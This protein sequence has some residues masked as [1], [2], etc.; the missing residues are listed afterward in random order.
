MKTL[1]NVY[2]LYIEEK[3]ENNINKL[4]LKNIES[5]N[6]GLDVQNNNFLNNLRNEVSKYEKLS[7]FKI[8]LKDN[9][10]NFLKSPEATSLQQNISNVS[11]G[12]SVFTSSSTNSEKISK[13]KVKKLITLFKNFLNYIQE[14]I[15]LQIQLILFIY[16]H[17]K[18]VFNFINIQ[19][20]NIKQDDITLNNINNATIKKTTEELENKSIFNDVK[21]LI[22]NFI[23]LFNRPA[24]TGQGSINLNTLQD[25]KNT[26]ERNLTNL[27]SNDGLFVK[28]FAYLQ[29]LINSF[30]STIK[31]YNINI[32]DTGLK[33]IK[34][35][36]SQINESQILEFI[37]AKSSKL[38]NKYD[39]NNT[40]KKPVD[41]L[42]YKI[43]NITPDEIIQYNKLNK[44]FNQTGRGQKGGFPKGAILFPENQYDYINSLNTIR[45]F[46]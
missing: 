27:I 17:I 9:L 19:I 30:E 25:I 18:I 7:I 3:T 29:S 36:I 26:Y 32:D 23:A 1:D 40:K 42:F 16:Y 20:Q 44:Y 11:N 37:K 2:S 45:Y 24:Q 38:K 12:S 28:T 39:N 33:E 21:S 43:E 13:N 15:V 41:E 34:T 14:L 22:D 4:V 5:E 31:S 35:S 6:D 10:D 46:I 8:K